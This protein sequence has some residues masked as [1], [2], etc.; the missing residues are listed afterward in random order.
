MINGKKWKVN[1]PET[2]KI[3]CIRR[4]LIR[5]LKFFKILKLYV[6]AKTLFYF[7]IG[8]EN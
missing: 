1:L 7:Q 6:L 3:L 2:V 5:I 8:K 4:Q